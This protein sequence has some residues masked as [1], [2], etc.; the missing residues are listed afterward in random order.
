VKKTTLAK[1]KKFGKMGESY[2]DVI[3]RLIEE[4]KK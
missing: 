1:L 4:I 3:E 2:N